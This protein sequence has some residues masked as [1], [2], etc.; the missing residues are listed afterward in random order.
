MGNAAVPGY[1]DDVGPLPGFSPAYLRIH[2]LFSR[3]NVVG[4]GGVLLD[5]MA[6]QAGYAAFLSFTNWNTETGRGWHGPYI[7]ANSAVRNTDPAREGLFP[8][9]NDRRT[10]GDPT[11]AERGFFPL[12]HGDYSEFYAYGFVGEQA[13]ADPWGNPYVLQIPPS[14]AFTHPTEARRFHFARLVSAGPDGVLQ[15]PCHGGGAATAES[16]CALRLAGRLPGG[17]V[18]SRGDDIVLFLDRDDT[19]ERDE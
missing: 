2:N 19:Y 13:L 7:R 8:A 17:S 5:T 14:E 3:T 1:L 4:R 9:P 16:R 11:F 15:T 18:E 10:S 12:A 6:A